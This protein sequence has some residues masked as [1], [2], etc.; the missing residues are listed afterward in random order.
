MQTA[1][2]D[3]PPSPWLAALRAYF[4]VVGMGNLVWEAAQFP[5]YTIWGDG[6][7]EHLAL[8]L[9]HG[10]LGDVAIAGAAL[11]IALAL[12]GDHGWPGKTAWRVAIPVVLFGLAYT[13]YSEWINVE[14]RHTWTYSD[15][16]PRLPP[17]GIGAS[18]LLQWIVIPPLALWVARRR[19]LLSP[20]FGSARKTARST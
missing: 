9:M 8:A 14:I 18:P 5:L 20:T 19:A 16:M 11:A 17:L 13:I 2:K 15:L 6:S 3:G 1:T 4:M 12:F 7:R 10:T